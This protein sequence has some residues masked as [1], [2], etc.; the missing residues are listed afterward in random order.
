MALGKYNLFVDWN[1]DG[2]FADTG[3]DMSSLLLS[4][5][6]ERGRDFASQLTGRSIAGYFVARI[7]NL[8]GLYTPS[9]ASGSL[10][11]NLKPNRKVMFEWLQ[12]TGFSY[13]FPFTF[14][15]GPAWTGFVDSITPAPD[16]I[17]NKEMILR[18]IGPLGMV[19]AEDVRV[20][21]NTS[22][23]SDVAFGKVLDA[24]G[25]PTDD[26]ELDTGNT[27]FGRWWVN[28]KAGLEA[29]REIEASEGGFI[30]ETR[31]GKIVFQE[32]QA[33]FK[34]P[35]TSST[36]TWSDA[37][38]AA[39][40]YQAI[41]AEDPLPQ[42]F[43]VLEAEVRNYTVGSL[44]VLWT[45]PEAS[46]TSNSPSIA[47]GQTLVFTARF[48]NP[49]SATNAVAVNEWTTPVATT[50]VLLNAAADG[51]GTNLTSSLSISVDA[52]DK[53]GQ[54]MKISV[55][56]DGA[57]DAFVTKLQARGTPITTSDPVIMSAE[58]A[59]SITAFGRQRYPNPAPWIPTTSEAQ[60]WAD[61][62]LGIYKD[63][64]RILT[65]TLLAH[66]DDCQDEVFRADIG[67]RVTIVAN[68]DTALGINEDFFIEREM[69]RID[70]HGFHTATY[71][72]SPASILGG[73]WVLGTSKLGV[74][75]RLAY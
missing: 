73:F 59:T 33:R 32:R 71:T 62:N 66:R 5:E 44:A 24:A 36:G 11:G 7:K 17:G 20:G 56:N 4:V 68:N 63:P 55:T 69:H 51:T 61:F 50:D 8:D 10:S 49:Q 15:G 37:S 12:T 9:N 57:T 70:G 21:M 75:T 67:D 58:D 48:P 38:G 23:R 42:I 41:T 40:P 46:G 39:T 47:G 53:L 18:A 60:N 2:D 43:N 30:Y 34:A 25:W 14:T 45:L 6:W 31:D 13:S 27:T 52:A 54:T 72:L 64:L 65:V 22:V 16:V 28:L 3:E 19:N 35:H 74:A 29:L 26:R 1:N